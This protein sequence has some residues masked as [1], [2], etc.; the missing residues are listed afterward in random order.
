MIIIDCG[1]GIRRLGADLL[2]TRKGDIEA[3]ILLS[4]THWDHIQ[5]LPFFDPLLRRSND[6]TMV[7]QRRENIPLEETVAR[8]FL[9]PYLPFAFR[10]LAAG[11]RMIEKSPGETYQIGPNTNV[12][13]GK[14]RH[15]G[16]CLGFRIEDEGKVLAYCSDTAHQGSKLNE[17][18]L[19]LADSAH[20]L[21]HDAHF[22]DM[23]A[24]ET[25]EH[26]GHSCW[27]QATLVAEAAS[28]DMLAL[29]HYAPAMVDDE[30]DVIAADA[31]RAYART[32][33]A[34]EGLILDLPVA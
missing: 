33:A 14:M 30:I 29:F 18:V 34:R 9:E 11:L 10:S 32:I 13:M 12:T 7:G 15:P 1:T 3:T 26:W 4:H 24:A 5:G 20:L 8:Q 27:E 16:G 6:F 21:I 2:R 31:R 22:P 25:F 19:A 17:D 23:A 28:A